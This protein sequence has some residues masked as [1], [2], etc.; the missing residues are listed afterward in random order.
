M[1]KEM[2][3]RFLSDKRIAALYNE[4]STVYAMAIPK[5]FIKEDDTFKLFYDEKVEHEVNL[6]RKIIDDLVKE[7][8]LDILEEN[9]FCPKCKS[10]TWFNNINGWRGCEEFSWMEKCE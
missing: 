6:I 10:E 5:G 3:I 7:E 4:I 9:P 1:K 2:Q 8:Y